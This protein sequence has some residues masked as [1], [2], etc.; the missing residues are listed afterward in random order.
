MWKHKR[1]QIKKAILNNKNN[2]GEINQNIKLQY[3]LL[4]HC[5][6]NS[7]HWH[8]NRHEHEFNRIEIPEMIPHIF[9][10][11]IFISKLKSIQ[12]ER[13]VSST[14]GVGK[15][16]STHVGPYLTPYTKI[17]SVWIYR[18]NLTPSSY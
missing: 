16:G 2:A 17:S 5:N 15:I 10:Y 8:K 13:A 1:S 9:Y 11:L 18:Y 12:G 4:G 3:I 7:L 14:N 6:Q